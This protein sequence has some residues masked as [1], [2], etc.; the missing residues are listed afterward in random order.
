MPI[1]DRIVRVISESLPDALENNCEK[2][3][4]K[5]REGSEKVIRFL[6]NKVRSPSPFRR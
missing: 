2:C 3:S 5:Q 1:R 4:E 6:I